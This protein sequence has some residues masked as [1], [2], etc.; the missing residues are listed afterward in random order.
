M[1]G[2][3]GAVTIGISFEISCDQL[4]S[5]ITHLQGMSATLNVV[6]VHWSSQ[7]LFTAMVSG[8]LGPHAL[9]D[10]LVEWCSFANIWRRLAAHTI[11]PPV[12]CVAILPDDMMA[13]DDSELHMTQE[14]MAYGASQKAW[15]L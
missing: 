7:A 6:R 14:G 2:L 1:W 15:R 3:S 11:A 9:G 8:T 5:V 10:F 12:P 4:L 13:F